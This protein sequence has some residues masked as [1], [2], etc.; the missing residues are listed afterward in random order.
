MSVS[1][2][3]LAFSLDLQNSTAASHVEEWSRNILAATQRR[4]AEKKRFVCSELRE[5]SP[6]SSPRRCAAA[7]IS[8]WSLLF[9]PS[10]ALR[11]TPRVAPFR[12][13]D[14]PQSAPRSQRS[15]RTYYFISAFSAISAVNSEIRVSR[16]GNAPIHI[17]FR[18]GGE[19]GIEV[20]ERQVRRTWC[21]LQES[22]REMPVRHQANRALG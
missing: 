18:R 22:P 2:L 4:S 10:T 6:N 1:R 19:V 17:A 16:I 15:I 8:S 11:N 14:S 13:R 20:L 3:S 9:G 7:R 5:L 21:P 12:Q